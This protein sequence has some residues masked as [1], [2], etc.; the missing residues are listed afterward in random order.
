MKINMDLFLQMSIPN[1][2]T[3][4]DAIHA[5]SPGLVSMKLYEG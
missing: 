2:N 5:S 3:G 1:R 4:E